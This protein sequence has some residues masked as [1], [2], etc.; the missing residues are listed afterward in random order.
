MKRRGRRDIEI[1]SMSFLDV[2]SCGFG[3]VILLLV[4]SL[5]FEPLNVERISKDLRGAISER[6]SAR[7]G[8]ES[9]T[10]DINRQLAEKRR[11][12]AAL[13]AKLD[14]LGNDWQ[15]ATT[16]LQQAQGRAAER[17]KIESELRLVRQNLSDEMRR[18]A[19]QADNR[20]P[21]PDAIIGGIPV[22]SEYIIFVID[23]SGS[24]KSG[25]WPLVIRKVEEVLKVYPRV[26]GI[27]V[28]SDM[29]TYMFPSFAGIWIPDTPARRQL[30]IEQMRRWNAF[31]NSSPVEGIEASIRAFYNP[32]RPT[33]IFVFGDD[34][35][36]RSVT[37]VV[38]TVARL[39][40]K[41]A[42]GQSR[43]RI[44]TFGFP[45]LIRV[46]PQNMVRFAHL[47]RL[48]AEQNSGSFVGLNSTR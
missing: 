43:V 48:L 4:V 37:K 42:N 1:Y 13:Q 17:S 40:P 23:T 24:M 11:S 38:E 8:L 41:T 33:S 12:L 29:G 14:G 30:V 47:M 45:T 46:A 9:R 44:H 18:L 32:S 7:K 15:K 26:K 27:Q 31:S 21:D 20:L 19:S 10:Q 5:A 35:N 22:D 2:I 25:A 34:F 3:A 36:G 16:Q 6:E 28:M 39:N